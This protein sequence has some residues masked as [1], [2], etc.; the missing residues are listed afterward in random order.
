MSKFKRGQLVATN[1]E[2]L[3]YGWLVEQRNGRWCWSNRELL[4]VPT[5]HLGVCI[6]DL[7]YVWCPDDAGPVDYL[8]PSSLHP[9]I[10]E[11]AYEPNVQVFLIEGRTVAHEISYFAAA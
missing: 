4:E 7:E 5:K 2:N 9:E 1:V 3:Q 6:D 11:N 10:A 8:A